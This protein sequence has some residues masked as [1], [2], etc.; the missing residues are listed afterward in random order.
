M[1]GGMLK[2]PQPVFI[3]LSSPMARHQ[4]TL[5][6]AHSV[7]Q[8]S[9]SLDER[10]A[11][12]GYKRLDPADQKVWR[13]GG[14]MANPI[15]IR[16]EVTPGRLLLEAWVRMV[17]LPGVYLGEQDLE[18]MVLIVQKRELR[19]HLAELEQLAG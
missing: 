16:Y 7:E 13:K 8:L 6:T 14:F 19:K 11:K 5:A 12:L 10:L 9:R 18:G 17:L 3:H 2:A 15:F 4:K 1:T